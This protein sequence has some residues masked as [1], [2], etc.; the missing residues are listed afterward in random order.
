MIYDT[1]VSLYEI[2]L[3][4]FAVQSAPFFIFYIIPINLN[5]VRLKKLCP[6][7]QNLVYENPL[8]GH[9]LLKIHFSNE[10]AEGR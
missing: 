8:I 10:S 2:I 7:V 9:F 5:N 4:D 6:L 3:L 1:K